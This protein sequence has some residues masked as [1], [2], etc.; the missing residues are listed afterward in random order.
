VHRGSVN[1]TFAGARFV[2]ERWHTGVQQYQSVTAEIIAFAIAAHHGQFDCIAPDGADGFLH[3]LT[4]E[5][6]GYTQ[7]KEQFLTHCAQLAELDILFE[8]AVAEVTAALASCRA[9]ADNT[10]ELLF[11]A[12]MMARQ[13]LSSVIEGDRR[14]TAEFMHFD[15]FTTADVNRPV[16]WNERLTAIEAQI[17][18][19]P[20]RAE[21]DLTR[22]RISDICRSAANGKNGVFRLTVPTGGGKTL[23]ALRYA[24]AAAAQGKRRIFFVIPLL[25]VLEQNAAVLRTYLGED[26]V[27][28]HH[29]NV[30]REKA[31]FDELDQNELLLGNWCAPVVITTLVQLLNTLFAGKTSCIRRMNALCESV[32]IVDEVQSV[33]RKMLSEFNLAINFLSG[34]CG[35]TVVLCSATQPCFEKTAHRLRVADRPELVPYDCALWK[36]FKRTEI[37]DRRLPQGYTAEELTD[38]A[39]ECAEQHKSLLLICNTKSQARTLFRQMRKK[40]DGTLFHLSTSMCMEHRIETMNAINKALSAPRVICVSTQ[41]VEAGVDFS[42]GCVIRVL[43]G[44]DNIVQS[45]GRCNRSGECNQPAPVYIVNIRGE[46]LHH[47][48]EIR[49]TQQAAESLLL[50]FSRNPELFQNDL[51]GEA[52]IQTYYHSLYAEMKKNSQDYPLPHY[53]TTLFDL[54]SVN[55]I[56]RAHC[57]TAQDKTIGQAFKTAGEQF[58]VFEDNTCDVLVPYGEGAQIIADFAST[59]ALYD[60]AYQAK[61]IRKA[62]RFCVS[63]YEYEIKRVRDAGGIHTLCG[64]A[65][66]VL[67][68]GF[69]ENEIGFSM[70]EHAQDGWRA[71][72]L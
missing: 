40:W 21:I 51:T 3:R 56:S 30:V 59:H 64:G 8:N 46:T 2:M 4:T 17:F 43:A 7:A 36:Q 19:L 12:S 71:E 29:S 62:A 41:L 50:R 63:L 27:L 5:G 25:S 69:Y 18:A 22:R 38:F 16:N 28:E 13:L 34:F 31:E 37:I 70:D 67:C 15:A 47:L 44:M 57:Q 11:Y 39:L 32:I 23:S 60:T 52:A 24:V 72:L 68:P 48:Q 45:A 42:F 58:H 49:Q 26:I 14:D 66:T 1:H 9:F 20:V 54:L 65:I 35:A 55:S 6:T 33:P 10:E 61:L 53:G